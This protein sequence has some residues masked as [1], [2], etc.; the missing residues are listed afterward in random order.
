MR[1]VIDNIV[2][3]SRN[4]RKNTGL[5]V[6]V[7]QRDHCSV[8]GYGRKNDASVEPPRG[9]SLFEIGSITKV[10]TT[11]LL[12]ISVADGFLNLDDPVRDRAPALSN[13]PPEMTLIRLAT[14]TSGL[15][16][17][18]S[19]LLRSMLQNWR[20]PY[21]AYTTTDLL[22]ALSQYKPKRTLKSN[23]Q[24]S[25]SNLGVALLGH[26]LAQRIG[27][28]YEQAVVGRIC[29]QLDMP[30]T[31]ITLTPGQKERLSPP[32]SANGKPGH[33]WDLPAFAGAG[34]LRSTA[35][36]MLKFLAANLGSSQAALTDA[37]LASH[38]TQIGTF[39]QQGR[40]RRL[41][42]GLIEKVQDTSFYQQ[43]IALGWIVG[44]LRAGGHQVHWHHGATGGYRAFTGFVK[45][46]HA[47]VIVLANRGLGGLDLL[48]NTTSTDVIGFRVL[49]HLS[50][51]N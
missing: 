14:H 17:M 1:E 48:F 10:F 5:V 6:G 29:D 23:E 40:L 36:D 20:N 32:H 8:F 43:G 16:K 12:S 28:S 34:A 11:T 37:L 38:I 50:S 21:A 41:A 46:T 27:V 22:K 15:P 4:H 13:L 19:N 45:A 3:S 7:I 47:G 25:Y 26:I 31:R 44:R 49:E 51:S 35:D 33:N 30:D 9:D 18:P 2:D 39:P 42:S 24:I